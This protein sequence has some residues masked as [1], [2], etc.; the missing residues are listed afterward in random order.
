MGGR[1]GGGQ[2]L[3]TGVDSG[4]AKAP[5]NDERRSSAGSD[6]SIKAIENEGIEWK[7]VTVVSSLSSASATASR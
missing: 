4:D 7:W 2:Q 3:A 1:C 5:I 6:A